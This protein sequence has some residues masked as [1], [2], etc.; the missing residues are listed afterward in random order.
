M[1]LIKLGKN[2]MNLKHNWLYKKI[3]MVNLTIKL[4]NFNNY[5]K[6]LCKSINLSTL[7][8]QQKSGKSIVNL[9]SND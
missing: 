2:V 9:I 7:Y 1:K 6:D 3:K 5:Q 8:E 4:H